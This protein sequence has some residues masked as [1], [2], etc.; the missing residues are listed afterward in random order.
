MMCENACAVARNAIARRY[1]VVIGDVVLGEGVEAYRAGLAG[2]GAEVHLV[3]L[4]PSLEVAEQRDT[5]GAGSLPER[6]RAL[7]AEFA[8]AEAAGRQ[9]GV[10]LDTSEDPDPY[11]T[12]D[13]LQDAVSRGLARFE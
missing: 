11:V 8:E 9:P 1:A 6:V 10:V 2:I 13:R 4:L 7:Y 3:T 12:A 5:G